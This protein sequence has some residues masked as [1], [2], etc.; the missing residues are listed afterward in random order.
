MSASPQ[1]AQLEAATLEYEAVQARYN[2]LV[3]GPTVADIAAARAR[4]VAAQTELESLSAQETNRQHDITLLEID[5][6]RTRLAREQL[7]AGIDP[8]LEH[9]VE[10]A[11]NDLAKALLSA[12][13]DGAIL[14]VMVRPGEMVGPGTDLILIAD[15]AA[16]EVRTTVIE[17]DL[18][19]VGVGQSVELYFDAHP[20]DAVMG[21]VSR[22][23]PQRVRGEDRPLYYVYIAPDEIPAGIAAGMTADASIIIDHRSDVLR[24]PRALVRARSDGTADVSVWVNGR[25][26]ERTIQVGLRGDIY[27]EIVDGLRVGEQVVG[28]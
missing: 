11:K 8:T 18:P 23:V 28:E 4:V 17:E 19:L 22:I 16:L 20:G 1:A 27:I 10:S 24:L 12:P 25:E 13:I 26:V 3:Q 2:L 7:E 15:P 5:L 6:Q 14:E 21:Q 9:D